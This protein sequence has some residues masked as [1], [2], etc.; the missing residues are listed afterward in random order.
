MIKVS[1]IIVNF[2]GCQHTIRCIESIQRTH[3]EG[4]FEVIVIDNDSRD[5]SVEAIK[6]QYPNVKVIALQQNLGFGK[7]N[8]IGADAS[9]SEY[10]FF[11]NNDTLFKKD[12]ITPLSQF[13]KENPSCGAIGPLLLNSDGTYQH[14]YGKFPSLMNELRTKKDTTLFKNI[15]KNRSPRQVDW[16]SFA[17]VMIRRSAFEKVN[18]FD[19]RYFMYFEDADLCFR[20][21]KAGFQSFYCAEYS[22]IHIGGGSR[23]HEITNMIKTEYRHSQLLFYASHRSWFELL[24]LRFYL[25]FRFSYPFLCTR[26]EE[27]RRARSVIIM[28]LSS[29]AHRS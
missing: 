28:A 23:S 1:I 6:A 15:P 26:G 27:H 22:L 5:G 14:S 21:Q 13:L 9:T 2:N 17:A 8:N 3:E 10:L 16:V 24:A 4:C 25:L 18:G 12:I 7:A 19:E 11:I 20:L 29:Y